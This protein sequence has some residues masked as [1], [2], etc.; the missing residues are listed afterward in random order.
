MPEQLILHASEFE[1][2]ATLGHRKFFFVYFTG[3]YSRLESNDTNISSIPDDTRI[4]FDTR[5]LHCM[6][7]S[8]KLELRNIFGCLR[9]E[10]S[11]GE[12]GTGIQV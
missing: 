1:T 8:Y 5:Y 3:I 9:I 11:N 12:I 6:S 2:S 4:V 10:N 7:R